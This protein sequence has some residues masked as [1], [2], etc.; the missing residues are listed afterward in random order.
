MKDM[1]SGKRPSLKFNALS[2]LTSL[3]INVATGL[4]ITRIVFGGLDPTSFGMW[5][6]TSSVVGYFGLLQM[7]VGTGVMRYVPLYRGQG[8]LDDVSM[9]VSTAMAFY[10]M[11]GLLILFLSLL[12]ANA[13]ASFFDGGATLAQL[14][15]IVGFAAAIECPLYIY[16][17]ALRSYERFAFANVVINLKAFVKALITWWCL[18][19]GYGVVGLGWSLVMVNIVMLIL[20]YMMFCF[21]C[22][23]VK[24]RISLVKFSEMRTLGGYSVWIAIGS[25]GDTLTFGSAKAIIGKLI[26][27][28]AV[29]TFGVV[30]QLSNYYRRTTYAITKPFM[31]RFSFL[32]G[33]ESHNE[34]RRLFV[35]ANSYLTIFT[36]LIAVFLW[37]L[38][39]AFMKVVF[40]KD[41]SGMI[42]VLYVLV[43]G[44]LV[45]GS[46]RMVIDLLYGLG[47]QKALAWFA[48]CEGAAVLGLSLWL[49]QRHGVL[50]VAAAI[51]IPVAIMRGVVQPY[52]VC[53]LIKMSMWKYYD[54]RIVR[55]WL[56]IGGISG[57]LVWL[58]A[59]SFATN[60]INLIII[61]SAVVFAYMVI[62]YALGLDKEE[63]ADII[64]KAAA[65]FKKQREAS[66]PIA[67][68]VV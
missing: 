7:G 67:E 49:V 11:V 52:Y 31:P 13:I 23:E 28:D 57:L 43:G 1:I 42:P 32:Q 6:L 62:V 10:T 40:D 38:G 60:W 35:R 53:R 2:N 65:R 5:M 61:S 45:L 29:G 14:I 27:L 16:D 36:G 3:V 50:G 54:R 25:I 4:Y 17:A 68:E 9:I 56:I 15:R 51:S 33:Q 18:H 46:N 44:M 26:S 47:K 22:R 19:L 37:T 41:M 21:A 20:A 30:A 8:R 59:G 66:P 55:L 63:R 34:I 64:H 48:I 24:L 58:K 39:S 12:L